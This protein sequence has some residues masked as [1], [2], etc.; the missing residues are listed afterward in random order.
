M[1]TFTDDTVVALAS[2]LAPHDMLSLALAC[3]R[4]G[5]KH[6]ATTSRSRRLAARESRKSGEGREVRQ[7]IESISLMEVSARTVLHS[8]WTDDEK[9]SL[10]RQGDESWIGLYQEFLKLFR[11]PLQFDKLAGG[12]MKYVEGS[13]KTTVCTNR[14]RGEENSGTAICS[15]IM[16]AGHFRFMPMIPC[17]T[18]IMAELYVVL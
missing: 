17:S 9:S 15:N 11:F 2:F 3:K 4:F 6:G 13:N 8:K 7:R 10:P 18:R 1:E 5:D 12:C 16:R 14:L